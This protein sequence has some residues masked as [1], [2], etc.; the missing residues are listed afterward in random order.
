LKHVSAVQFRGPDA[1]SHRQ[2]AEDE[3][4]ENYDDSWLEEIALL[5]TIPEQCAV[6]R[7]NFHKAT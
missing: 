5:I 1:L 6:P 2:P 7:F 4:V 3:E